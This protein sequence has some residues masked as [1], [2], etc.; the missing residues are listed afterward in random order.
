MFSVSSQSGYWQL[1][2]HCMVVVIEKST[3]FLVQERRVIFIVIL[4]GIVFYAI[5]LSWVGVLKVY[6]SYY[7]LVLHF[8]RYDRHVFSRRLALAM[9]VVLL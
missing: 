9:M 1:Y 4:L 7:S 3:Y 2:H 5:T 8:I 6:I